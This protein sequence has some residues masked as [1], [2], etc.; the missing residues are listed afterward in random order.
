LA[1][2]KQFLE[3]SDAL[4]G[5]MN[6]LMG[7]LNDS[8]NDARKYK[9]EVAQLAQNISSLNTVYGNMLSAMNRTQG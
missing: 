7:T 1:G 4:Y 6:E 8:V 3:T 5:G 2:T 9:D